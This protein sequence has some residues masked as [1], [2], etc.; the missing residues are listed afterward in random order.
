[1]CEN[2][3]RMSPRGQMKCLWSGWARD[4][5]WGLHF[6]TAWTLIEVGVREGG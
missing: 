5:F 3:V 1:M 6:M 2:K 4:E